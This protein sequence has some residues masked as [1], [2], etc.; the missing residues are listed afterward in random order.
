MDLVEGRPVLNREFHTLG[1]QCFEPVQALSDIALSNAEE[2]Q[3]RNLGPIRLE[4]PCEIRQYRLIG[5]SSQLAGHAGH[6]IKPTSVRI[7]AKAHRCSL[8]VGQDRRPGREIRLFL[9][10]RGHLAAALG[11]ELAGVFERFLEPLDLATEGAGHCLSGHVVTGRTQPTGDQ[12]RVGP[13]GS[14]R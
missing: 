4:S 5:H 7:E 11:K 13:A 3:G 6:E 1:D 2:L 8:G 9:V 14:S 12:H 10:G